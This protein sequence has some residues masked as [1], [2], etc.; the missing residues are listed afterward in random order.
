MATFTADSTGPITLDFTA[1][2][3]DVTIRTSPDLNTATMKM[4]GPDDVLSGVTEH[5]EGSRWTVRLPDP[6]PTVITGSSG[7]ARNTVFGNISGATMIM[8]GGDLTISGGTAINGGGTFTQTDPVK[9]EI[10]LP[11]RS[12]AH[13]SQNIGQARLHGHYADIDFRS[14]NAGLEMNGDADYLDAD[15]TNGS[16]SVSGAVSEEINT[17]AT[18]GTLTLASSAP[19]TNA[20]ATNGSVTVKASGPHRIRARTTNGSLTVLKNGHD[21]DVTSSTTNGSELVH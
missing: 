2:I 19:R 13:L 18:N 4:T 15:T 16:I 21:A 14:S 7:G 6:G 9:V 1:P 20:R 5:T 11:E 8:S 3:A 17:S 12:S 10:T